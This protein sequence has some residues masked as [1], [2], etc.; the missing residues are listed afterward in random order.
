M[1]CN[2]QKLLPLINK[3]NRF[4]L[5]NKYLDWI[6]ICNNIKEKLKN[7]DNLYENQ[8][9]ENI[10]H[11]VP[12][13]SIITTDVGQNQVWV[14]QSFK[15]KPNQRI[16]FSGGHGAMGYS[17][18]AA[19]GAYYASNKPIIC[20]N[21]DGGFQMNIQELQF[22]A[23]ENLPIKIIILNNHSLGMIRHF[24]EMYFDSRYNQTVK[25][26]GYEIPDFCNIA[27]AYGIRSLN[28]NNHTE[29]ANLQNILT[30]D[31][32]ILINI[33]LNNTTYIYPKLTMGNPIYDQ[34]PKIDRSL[35]KEI[36]KY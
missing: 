2:I 35:L 11:Q 22:I 8:I 16:L 20:F 27:K 3:D 15:V 13:N 4:N 24:Q 29:I 12:D 18:P 33:N 5:K 34:E 25:N 17:L 32:P 6:K 21:G 31:L 26:Y 28:I 14:A 9:I 10:S 19:I 23:R 36:F 7:I 1:N 30:D